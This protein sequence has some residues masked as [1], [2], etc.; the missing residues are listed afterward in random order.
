MG[1]S[2][3]SIKERFLSATMSIVQVEQ[4]EAIR[5]KAIELAENIEITCPEGREKSLALTKLEEVSMWAIKAIAH[6][7]S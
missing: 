3:M 2:K 7:H 1:D 4:V 5:A 6:G